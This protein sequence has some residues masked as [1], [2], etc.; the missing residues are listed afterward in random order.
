MDIVTY[1]ATIADA[2]DL[3]RDLAALCASY[4]AND[5]GRAALIKRAFNVGNVNN[6]KLREKLEVMITTDTCR[7]GIRMFLVNLIRGYYADIYCDD[8]GL[9]K[10]T[11]LMCEWGP[12]LTLTEWRV[13]D[14][15]YSSDAW[16]QE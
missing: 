2:I 5:L 4:C 11:L 7:V 1:R 10:R 3:P 16:R 8:G 13:L 14:V 15:P 9:I 6:M 12:Y